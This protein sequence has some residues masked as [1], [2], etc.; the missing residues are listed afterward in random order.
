MRIRTKKKDLISI[1]TERK[2]YLSS[3]KPTRSSTDNYQIIVI[4]AFID[5]TR[6]FIIT[7]V[8]Q[9]HLRIPLNNSSRSFILLTNEF[10]PNKH[11]RNCFNFREAG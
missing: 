3:S 5:N 9:Y 10:A 11:L 7:V 6:Q 2:K 1:V 4:L 8:F